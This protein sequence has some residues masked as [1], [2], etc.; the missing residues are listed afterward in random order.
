MKESVRDCKHKLSKSEIM[1]DEA[2][3]LI[4]KMYRRNSIQK[5]IIKKK[6]EIKMSLYLKIG[7]VTLIATKWLFIE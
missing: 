3:I 7:A 1:D 4:R 2:K 5:G 6:G